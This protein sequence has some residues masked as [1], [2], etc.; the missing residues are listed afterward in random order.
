[1]AGGAG[2][3][4]AARKS[5]VPIYLPLDR[6]PSNDDHTKLEEKLEGWNEW[7]AQWNE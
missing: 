1:M 7:E 4:P 3:E 5:V 2:L 6:L